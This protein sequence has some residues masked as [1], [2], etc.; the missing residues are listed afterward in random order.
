MTHVVR[1]A[2]AVC[3]VSEHQPTTL[4]CYGRDIRGTVTCCYRL[5]R[6]YQRLGDTAGGMGLLRLKEAEMH[7][8][9]V[10][11]VVAAK[12]AE[13]LDHP[14]LISFHQSLDEQMLDA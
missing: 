10:G 11:T 14:S 8:H 6:I 4:C 13:G 9:V 1:V 2:L 7:L 5:A 12:E 3:W